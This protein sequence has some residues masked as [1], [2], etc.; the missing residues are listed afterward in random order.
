MRIWSTARAQWVPCKLLP[1]GP[2][3]WL[4]NQPC[5]SFPWRRALAV[6]ENLM[7]PRIEDVRDN[8]C[9]GEWHERV[10]AAAAPLF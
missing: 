6:Y 3:P 9:V 4:N 1:A 5:P 7:Q 2:V 10:G 8:F